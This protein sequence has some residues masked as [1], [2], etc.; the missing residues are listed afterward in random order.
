MEDQ[1]VMALEKERETYE[2]HLDELLKDEG[3]FALVHGDELLGVFDTY[4]AAIVDG[5]AKCGLDPFLVRKIERFE[6]VQFVSRLV[7][8]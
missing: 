2:R 4:E 7:I 1:A 3:R 6:S 8:A 5:Y